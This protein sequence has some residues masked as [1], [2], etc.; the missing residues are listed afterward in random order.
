[1]MELSVTQI[2]YCLLL[3]WGCSRTINTCHSNRRQLVVEKLLRN[4]FRYI[5]LHI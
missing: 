1:M 5:T 4:V 3:Y 2:R